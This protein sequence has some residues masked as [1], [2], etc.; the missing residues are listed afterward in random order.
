MNGDE[1]R[2]WKSQGFDNSKIADKLIEKYGLTQSREA[3][4]KR[5]SRLLK[6]SPPEL[7]DENIDSE[8][9]R[10]IAEYGIRVEKNNKDGTVTRERMFAIKQTDNKDDETLMRLHGYDPDEWDCI[11]SYQKIWNAYSKQDGV[12]EL[13]SSKITV[14][15]KVKGITKEVVEEWWESIVSLNPAPY[16][17]KQYNAGEVMGIYSPADPHF[18][19]LAW[20]AETG[21]SYDH[22]IAKERYIASAQDFIDWIT[23][24]KPELILF[25][26]T[27]DFFHIDNE[28]G[29][30]SGGTPQDV[31]GRTKKIIRHGLETLVEVVLMLRSLCPVKMG[32][33]RSNHAELLE[34]CATLGLKYR[35]HNDEAVEIDTSPSPRHYEVYGNS[36]L[37]FSH[38]EA[39]DKQIPSL[40]QTERPVE[41]GA[42]KYHDWFTAHL[43]TKKQAFY[44]SDDENGIRRYWLPS[45]AGPDAWHSEK[46]YKGAI[47]STQSFIYHKEHGMIHTHEYKA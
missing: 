12:V 18:G 30:T 26:W 36:L 17:T 41:W 29:T 45:M 9:D 8:I 15:P 33:T 10:K 16:V 11:N 14:K 5:V 22:K 20:W 24:Y 42:T 3:I 40:M 23:P 43:H 13:C 25:P 21:E 32:Y 34:Y 31:D 19:K 37:G 1:I 47:K 6:K 44:V 35:F 39:D 4:R 7:T 27:Q 28:Q 46:G 38:G 2:Q